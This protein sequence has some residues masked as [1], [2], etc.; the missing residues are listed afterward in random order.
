MWI[1]RCSLGS[2]PVV[3]SSLSWTVDKWQ[4]SD[5]HAVD[6]GDRKASTAEAVGRLRGDPGSLI[7]DVPLVRPSGTTWDCP[8]RTVCLL[9]LA[10]G[11]EE[12]GL[13]IECEVMERGPRCRGSHKAT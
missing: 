5:G 2:W 1:P 3:R 10:L 7:R 6:G 13:K 8:S 12:V 9:E 11:S 4:E